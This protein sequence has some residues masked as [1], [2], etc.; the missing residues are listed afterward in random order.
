MAGIVDIVKRAVDDVDLADVARRNSSAPFSGT[1]RA[2][3]RKYNMDGRFNGSEVITD[4]RSQY[5]QL[6]ARQNARARRAE[7]KAEAGRARAAE[8]S[9]RREPTEYQAALHTDDVSAARTRGEALPSGVHRPLP[10]D[11]SVEPVPSLYSEGTVTPP[12]IAQRVAAIEAV[13]NGTN[14]LLQPTN[15]EF[16]ERTLVREGENIP[17]A[18]ASGNVVIRDRGV[19]EAEARALYNEQF[20]AMGLGQGSLTP[21][22]LSEMPEEE[23]KLLSRVNPLLVE[24]QETGSVVGLLRRQ[25]QLRESV[26]GSVNRLEGVG[27]TEYDLLGEEIRRMNDASYNIRKS[28]GYGPEPETATRSQE[29]YRRLYDERVYDEAVHTRA[30][31]NTATE[32]MTE[33]VTTG[34]PVASG[35]TGAFTTTPTQS[36]SSI[37]GGMDPSTGRGIAMGVGMG[38]LLGGTANYA[39]GGEFSEG[40]MMGGLAG[41]GIMIGAR[42]IG[43]NQDQI[44]NYMQRQVLGDAFVEGADNAASVRALSDETVGRLGFGQRQAYNQLMRGAD[45]PRMQARH[46]VIGGSMLAGVAF[47]GRRNDKRRGFN[48]HRGNR[49]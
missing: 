43:A 35:G 24:A 44:S 46:A 49:I 21:R 22:I 45:T 39:M 15:R 4:T 36:S 33:G 5:D 17:S 41:G 19:N 38:A 2:P 27:R 12:D 37:L 6:Q 14:P 25:E 23:V 31:L 29:A 10:S 30:N 32:A 8:M 7:V 20:D 28:G 16:L 3:I 9:A 48:A 11:F 18:Y 13:K 47:T 40:A 26:G 1:R 34:T 42:A